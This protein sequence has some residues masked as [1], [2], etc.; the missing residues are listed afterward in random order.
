MLLL[1]E[2]AALLLLILLALLLLLALWLLF[3]ND[4]FSAGIVESS[5]SIFDVAADAAVLL[6][7]VA[8]IAR[9]SDVDDDPR[10]VLILVLKAA[11][12]LFA[13]LVAACKFLDDVVA[14][15]S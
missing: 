10:P 11:A 9:E 12:S 7:V 15:S 5:L 14:T 4:A 6:L 8:F 13:I 3:T 1:F 2:F